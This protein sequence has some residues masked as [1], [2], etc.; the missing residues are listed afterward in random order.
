M[1]DDKQCTASDSATALPLAKSLAGLGGNIDNQAAL[2]VVAIP[3]EATRRRKAEMVGKC[4][5]EIY[6]G[7]CNGD[8]I[9]KLYGFG[10]RRFVALIYRSYQCRAWRGSDPRDDR[11]RGRCCA[12]RSAA[13]RR[14]PS[15]DRRWGPS[16]AVRAGARNVQGCVLRG[17]CRPQSPVRCECQS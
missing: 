7:A 4:C 9:R 8:Q 14:S 3:L 16:E 6:A 12:P 15:K 5:A 17:I 13:C 2:D 11:K 10:Y 1:R